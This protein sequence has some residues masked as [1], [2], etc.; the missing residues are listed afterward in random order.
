[1]SPRQTQLLFFFAK[2]LVSAVLLY[3][4]FSTFSFGFLLEQETFLDWRLWIVGLCVLL[5]LV[6]QAWRWHLNLRLFDIDLPVSKSMRFVLIGMFFQL[7]GVGIIG[8]EAAR[9]FLLRSYTESGLI[10]SATLILVDRIMG[11]LTMVIMGV[12]FSIVLL[13]MAPSELGQWTL[14]LFSA[15]ATGAI[16]LSFIVGTVFVKQERFKNGWL[17]DLTDVYRSTGPQILAKPKLATH[18]FLVAILANF[19]LAAALAFAAGIVGTQVDIGTTATIIPTIVIA[20]TLPI[21]VAGLGVGETVAGTSFALLGLDNGVQ[22][23]FLV[24]I[25]LL[26]MAAVGGLLFLL[27]P[28]TKNTSKGMGQAG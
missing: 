18:A 7:S 19:A 25:W 23:M 26:A 24:R 12:I 4:L 20:N 9:T 14:L 21:S 15:G 17:H 6:G 10:K 5:N 16:I 1:M 27:T 11:L 3:W 28:S 22:S 8:G 13:A 2:C